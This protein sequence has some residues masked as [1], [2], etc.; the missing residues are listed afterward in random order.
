MPNEPTLR[1]RHRPPPKTVQEL[2][3]QAPR[4][5]A[6]FTG[7]CPSP[8]PCL[9]CNA[10]ALSTLLR[11]KEPPTPRAPP[12]CDAAG[13]ADSAEAGATAA[14]L[15]ISSHP[16]LPSALPLSPH[17]L[18]SL[19]LSHPLSFRSFLP[20]LSVPFR[21][22][23]FSLSVY[24]LSW[25]SSEHP[26]SGDKRAC[27]VSSPV[28]DQI[29]FAPFLSSE[30]PKADRDSRETPTSFLVLASSY[31]ATA[32]DPLTI[33]SVVPSFRRSVPSLP[34]SIALATVSS[35]LLS[36][37]SLFFLFFFVHSYLTLHLKRLVALRPDPFSLF[38]YL[39]TNNT[40]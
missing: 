18:A 17:P 27:F 7:V 16:S 29:C 21:F 13:R 33:R 36:F 12:P 26:L 14:Q 37:F 22:C 30:R 35:L 31:S 1:H 32:N 4:G 3:G 11:G 28:L 40:H 5:L 34:L 23:I 8:N 39:R 15:K 20:F 6:P 9:T 19:W 38:L 2:A 10:S 25:F 24:S